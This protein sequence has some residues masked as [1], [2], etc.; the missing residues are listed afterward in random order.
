MLRTT[1]SVLLLLFVCFRW[2]WS[3]GSCGWF[4]W[5]AV[6]QWDVHEPV[7]NVALHECGPALRSDWLLICPIGRLGCGASPTNSITRMYVGGSPGHTLCEPQQLVHRNARDYACYRG[8]DVCFVQSTKVRLMIW[9]LFLGVIKLYGWQVWV[10]VSVWVYA[11]VFIY[12]NPETLRIYM[13]VRLNSWIKGIVWGLV[14]M[15]TRCVDSRFDWV[16]AD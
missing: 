9:V 14:L 7:W 10:Y 13:A 1:L 2:S 5:S 4:G 12:A 3:D 11:C 16:S 8:E 15:C 6:C